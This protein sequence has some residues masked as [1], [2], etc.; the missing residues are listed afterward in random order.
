M[1]A[2]SAGRRTRVLHVIQNLH[3]GGMERVLADLARGADPSRF[4]VHVLGLQYLGRNAAGLSEIATLHVAPPQSRWSMVW[5]R[6]LTALMRSIAPDVVHS[7]SGVWYKASKAARHAGIRRIIHTDHGRQVPDPWQDRLLDRAASRRTDVVVAV[8]EPL[9]KKLADHVVA[10]PDRIRVVLNGVD[11]EAFKP[12][13][14][15]GAIRTALG[16]SADAP[17]LGTI[18]RLERVKGYD[19]MVR[20]LAL[21]RA[22][23]RDGAPP[24]LIFAGE[25]SERQKLQS[26]A[27]ELGVSDAVHFLGWR[28]DVH[29]L[30]AMF[31]LFSLSSLSEGTSISLLEAM[32]A[33]R[34]PVVTDVG[35][36]SAVLGPQLQH[37]LVKSG[38]HEA[39]AAGWRDALADPAR[40]RA[41]ETIARARVISAYSLE[42]TVRAYEALYV[43]EEP[44]AS[45]VPSPVARP[46]TG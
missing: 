20:A 6:T 13:E 32:S 17:V 11:S 25:G 7:H 18:G 39:L 16:I 27:A 24:H 40:R 44:P 46:S 1:S 3:Y 42:A 37:R 5:P 28:D 10:F 26:L 21:L 34:C 30:H 4:E 41:D 2:T 14:D 43:S 36:N 22:D 33:G 35:G 19:L 45:R 9:A 8:S 31:T 15:N 38:D 12:M 29:D 23:W